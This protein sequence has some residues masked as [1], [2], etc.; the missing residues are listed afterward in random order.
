VECETNIY[1]DK[2]RQEKKMLNGWKMPVESSVEDSEEC[3]SDEGCLMNHDGS[4]TGEKKG[5]EEITR[6]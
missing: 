1:Y 2:K 5:P 6:Q 4:R 3:V